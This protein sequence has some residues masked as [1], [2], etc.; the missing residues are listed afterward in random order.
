MKGSTLLHDVVRSEAYSEEDF[1]RAAKM[2]GKK[3]LAILQL[4]LQWSI[5][6]DVSLSFQH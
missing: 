2:L 6:G 3:W 4:C 1:T 5:H